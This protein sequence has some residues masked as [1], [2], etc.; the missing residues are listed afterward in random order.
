M[1]RLRK[2]FAGLFLTCG[3]GGTSGDVKGRRASHWLW[4]DLTIE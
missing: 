4:R 3:S 2:F 1:R